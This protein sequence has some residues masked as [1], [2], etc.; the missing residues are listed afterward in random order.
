MLTGDGRVKV[1]DF[2]VARVTS[3]NATMTATVVG[4]PSYM[5]PEQIRGGKLDG[6]SDLFSAATVLYEMLTKSRPFPG[7]DIATTLYR[8]V[9]ELPTPPAE[10]NPAIGPELTAVFERAMAKDPNGRFPTGADLAKA[11]RQA[12]NPA[13]GKS[14]ARVLPGPAGATVKIAAAVA[15]APVAQAAP[16]KVERA[17]APVAAESPSRGM[18]M[19]LVGAA[20]AVLVL[21]VGGY[22]YFSRGAA[23]GPSTPTTQ[24]TDTLVAQRGAAPAPAAASTPPAAEPVVPTPVPEP[25]AAAPPAARGAAPAQASP[26]RG[27]PANTQSVPAGGR[28]ARGGS[29]TPTTAPPPEAAAVGQTASAAQT[30]SAPPQE[31]PAPPV[32]AV[33]VTVVFD[34]LN[35]A[36]TGL[37]ITFNGRTISGLDLPST[38]SGIPAG[39]YEVT[40]RWT[41]GSLAGTTLK[42][43]VNLRAGGS[44]RYRIKPNPNDTQITATPLS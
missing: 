21:G 10:F 27:G 40:Y 4:S 31:A 26:R 14:T 25:P 15:A 16:A 18:P 32:S 28:T 2:G 44:N 9:H 11:M 19:A 1:T 13:S 24:G 5:S 36:Y 41:S 12:S 29:Q 6:R 43:T 3:G 35:N 8:I 42:D 37:Q 17:A 39:T 33:R 20:A 22:M 30:T 23:T 7:D 34:V 38:V